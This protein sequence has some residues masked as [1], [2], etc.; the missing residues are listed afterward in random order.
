LAGAAGAAA[1][2]ATVGLAGCTDD[3]PGGPGDTPTELPRVGR[4]RYKGEIVV[5]TLQNPSP[6]AQQALTKAYQA[7]QP[8]VDVR[9]ETQDWPDKGLYA[10][11][12]SAQLAAAPTRPDIISG[13]YDPGFSNYVNLEEYRWRTNPYTGNVWDK[14]FLFTRIRELDP[15]GKRT[16]IGTETQHL[17]WYYNQKIF[18]DLKLTPPTNWDELVTVCESISATGITPLSVSLNDAIIPW[19]A[20]TYFDQYHTSWADVVRAR[21]GDWDWDPRRPE[22]VDDPDEQRLHVRYTFSPLRFYQALRDRRLRFNTPAVTEI[23]SNLGRIFPRYADAA[24]LL[25]GDHYV[26]FLQGKA[27]MMVDA[28]WALVQLARDLDNL[29]AERA[30]ELSIDAGSVQPFEWGVFDFPPMVSSLAASPIVRVPE[31]AVGYEIGVVGKGSQ[32]T[33]MTMD[34]LMFWLSKPGFSAFLDAEEAS[35]GWVPQGFPLVVDVSYP[36][37]VAKQ[38]EKVV[39][40]GNPLGTY[41]DFWV[42]GAGGASTRD[43]RGLFGEAVQG[44]VA[45]PE[46]AKQ[47]QAYVQAHFAELLQQAGLAAVDLANPA[48]RPSAL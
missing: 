47:L 10:T 9:W 7:Q 29:S 48:R 22:F 45:P 25:G 39:Q 5:A 41:S 37:D 31:Q 4:R 24:A 33:A 30:N 15:A 34:F 20:P 36:D 38:Q 13:E 26:P 32:Q 21:E 42:S 11:W 17:S 3:V 35:P 23:M 16:T 18:D 44:R 14:D 27:A 40:T 19:F 12:L 2:L 28:S 43:L 8:D 1:S 46:Y 6:A